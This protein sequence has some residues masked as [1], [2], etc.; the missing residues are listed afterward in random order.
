MYN[1]RAQL[2]T[3]RINWLPHL[4]DAQSSESDTTHTKTS[5]ISEDVACTSEQ[6]LLTWN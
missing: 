3:S 5:D 6:I 4:V 2:A 1:F